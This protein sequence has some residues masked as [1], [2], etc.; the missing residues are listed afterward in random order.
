MT[1]TE[2]VMNFI[3][4]WNEKDWAAVEASFS[5]DVVYHNIPMEPIHGKAAAGAVGPNM[6]PL[7]VDWQVL[8]IAESGNVV[9][10]ERVDNF[11]LADGK[12]LS[13]PV[14]GSMEIENGKIK[15]WRDYFDLAT[16]TSQMA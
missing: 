15:A 10:T 16:F 14:M 8:N 4:A 3:N 5:D 2:V 13:I 1:N 7:S 12:T 6:A 11:V 9:L